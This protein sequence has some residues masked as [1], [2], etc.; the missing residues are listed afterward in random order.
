MDITMP[1]VPARPRSPRSLR[2]ALA[3]LAVMLVAVFV[4][5][6]TP[7]AA[8]ARSSVRIGISDQ[9]TSMFAAPAYQRMKIKRVRYFVAWNVMD[10]K[11][12]RLRTRAYVKEARKEH[13]QVLLHL[14]TDDYTSK[15]AHLPT[16]REYRTQVR[17]LVRY[18]RALG[19][20]EFGVFNEANHA[21]EPTYRSPTRAADFF[22]EMYR[23]VKSTCR[24]CG[25][26]ALDVL[27]QRGV[28]KYMRSFYRHLSPTYRRRATIVGIHNY[29]DVN[30][31]RTTFTRSI[32]KQAHAYNKKTRFWLTETG[33]LVKLG[34]SFPFS[35]TRA[36]HRI[37]TLFSLVK[38]FKPSGVER[39]YYYN[40]QGTGRAARFDSGLVDENG[41]TRKGYT[42]LRKYLAR[43]NR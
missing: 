24:T 11:D 10:N 15:K 34:T 1:Q 26:V 40:W 5:A 18:F 42:T 37:D 4:S 36:A 9:N 23:A 14:S 43:Y 33:G 7:G 16:V 22:V 39:V 41:V 8:Q 19:V 27:D 12:A 20:R 21:S 29:G 6:A 2:G 17:R 35:P 25:V 31:R 30:R 38:R 28:E 32:I 13:T 3:C